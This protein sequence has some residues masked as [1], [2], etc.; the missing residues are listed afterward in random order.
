M[1]LIAILEGNGHIPLGQNHPFDSANKKVCPKPQNGS[2]MAVQNRKKEI[3]RTLKQKC[4]FD[5]IAVTLKSKSQI[6]G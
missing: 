1:H 2:F 6:F 5:K 4:R 3:V